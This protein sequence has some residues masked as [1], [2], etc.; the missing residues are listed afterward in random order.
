MVQH[1]QQLELDHTLAHEQE[2][3]K[4]EEQPPS[5]EGRVEEDTHL[6]LVLAEADVSVHVL[7]L[8]FD[9]FLVQALSPRIQNV[10]AADRVPDGIRQ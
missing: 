5:E 6:V 2:G 10:G 3:N 8:G 1:E 9:L 7:H 4:H